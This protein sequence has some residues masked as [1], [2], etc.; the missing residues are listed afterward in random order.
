MLSSGLLNWYIYISFTQH[1]DASVE[2]F[3][4]MLEEREAVRN[5]FKEYKLD[6]KEHGAFI[7]ELIMGKPRVNTPAVSILLELLF[8]NWLWGYN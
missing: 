1:E 8:A 5:E 4:H 3:R 2:M 7:E 6:V